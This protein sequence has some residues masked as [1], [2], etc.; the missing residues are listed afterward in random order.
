MEIYDRHARVTMEAGTPV[1]SSAMSSS[2]SPFLAATIET[3][4]TEASSPSPYGVEEAVRECTCSATLLYGND[5]DVE[6]CG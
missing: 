4:T 5:G 2:P 3:K 6:L 1:S